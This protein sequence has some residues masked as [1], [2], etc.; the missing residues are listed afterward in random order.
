[1]HFLIPCSGFGSDEARA[2]G[3]QICAAIHEQVPDDSTINVNKSGRNG[4]VFVDFSQNDYAD[5]I[6][7]PYCV[8]PFHVPLVSTP[9]GPK[10][11]NA[12][13]DPRKFDM[14]TM[15]KRLKQNGLCLKI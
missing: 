10:E 11:I 13:L 4:K 5:T 9:L 2:I 6:S 8:R 14:K 12:T 7:A 3:A 15:L 1:M